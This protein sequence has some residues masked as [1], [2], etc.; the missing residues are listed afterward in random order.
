LLLGGLGVVD[1][2][3]VSAAELGVGVPVLGVGRS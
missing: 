3:L 1:E 2:L